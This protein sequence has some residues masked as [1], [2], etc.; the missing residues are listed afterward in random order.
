MKNALV[1]KQVT[2]EIFKSGL[3]ERMED[4]GLSKEKESAE[5]QEFI[6]TFISAY[7]AAVKDFSDHSVD[8]DDLAGL[9]K[10]IS[11]VFCYDDSDYGI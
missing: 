4:F 9:Q 1:S 3:F 6:S 11:E 2:K 8:A 7:F 10:E 5:K